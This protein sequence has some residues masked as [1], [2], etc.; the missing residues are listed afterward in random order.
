MLCRLWMV[1]C[2]A[3]A[4]ENL[5][6]GDKKGCIFQRWQWLIIFLVVLI[7]LTPFHLHAQSA[8][9]IT[10]L[11]PSLGPVSPV[12]RPIT[13][14]GSGFGASPGAVTFGGVTAATNSWSDTSI[15]VLDCL[16]SPILSLFLLSILGSPF[17]MD[18][19]RRCSAGPTVRHTD[20]TTV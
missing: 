13:I 11:S 18:R 3:A 20:R 14:S 10:S 2:L 7:P 15:A 1:A 6:E 5:P 9:T 17:P 19:E 12:G 16:I 8:P 4:R